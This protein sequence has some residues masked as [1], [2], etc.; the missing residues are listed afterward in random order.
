MVQLVSAAQAPCCTG[1]LLHLHSPPLSLS[2]PSMRSPAEF[3]RA[4]L[5][6]VK[7]SPKQQGCSPCPQRKSLVAPAGCCIATSF[8]FC[9]SSWLVVASPLSIRS[10]AECARAQL[11]S[12]RV[13]P[14][15]QECSP[16][17]VRSP[18]PLSPQHVVA[19]N[20]GAAHARSPSPL[21]HR[22]V[23]ASAVFARH[24]FHVLPIKLA[25]CCINVYLQQ[26]G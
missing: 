2:L 26:P 7:T 10:P 13:P 17:R 6:S 21:L 23:V 16:A 4:E 14:K 3:A 25:G 19:S 12:A 15:Q 18:S 20:K 5:L 1:W 24:L 22:L 9:Q 11:E 8:M